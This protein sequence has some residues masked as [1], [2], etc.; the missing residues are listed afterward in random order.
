MEECQSSIELYCPRGRSAYCISNLTQD[1]RTNSSSAELHTILHIFIL[2]DRTIRGS[3]PIPWRRPLTTHGVGT[4]QISVMYNFFEADPGRSF[5]KYQICRQNAT[6][7][8]WFSDL[9][10]TVP[11]ILGRSLTAVEV[12]NWAGMKLGSGGSFSVV[13]DPAL[14]TC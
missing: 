1:N 5:I 7:S 6:Y 12:C 3:T 14:C 4:L 9:F 10:V 2:K 8:T 11:P 13:T